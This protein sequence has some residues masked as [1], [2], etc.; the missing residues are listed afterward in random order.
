MAKDIKDC[1]H[2]CLEKQK[3]KKEWSRNWEKSKQP[4]KQRKYR[5]NAPLHVKQKFMSSHLSKDLKIKYNARSLILRKG[6]TVKILR[7]NF[8]GESGKV[9][10]INIKDEKVYISG[11][12]IDKKDGTKVNRPIHPSNL[13]I[14][15]ANMDDKERKKI[16]KRKES[17]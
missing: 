2:N 16:I 10:R 8:K 15:E 11:I 13:T 6:D 5:F 14:I 12:T 7:G 9:D 3:M 1:K 17:K 4:R